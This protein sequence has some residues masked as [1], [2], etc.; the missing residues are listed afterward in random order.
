MLYQFV[1]LFTEPYLVFVVLGTLL[2][3]RSKQLYS[4]PTSRMLVRMMLLMWVISLPLPS[5][6]MINTLEGKYRRVSYEADSLDA[7][8]V[9]G[10]GINADPVTGEITLTR[11]AMARCLKAA[12]VARSTDAT[13]IVTGGVPS[14]DESLPS[15]ALVMKDFL[16]GIGFDPDRVL[17]EDKARSTHENAVEVVQIIR[18]RGDGNVGIVSQGWHLKR[19]VACFEHEGL[20]VIPIGCS[21]SADHGMVP[22]YQQFLPRESCLYRSHR[23]V[24]EWIGIGWYAFKDRISLDSVF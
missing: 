4:T 5:S 11:D 8:V 15:E 21:W 1:K 9:L 20:K 22:T 18:E 17:M 13:V 7:V 24:Q 14:R 12:E 23:S 19:S 3:L 6:L 10:G 2:A 16:I